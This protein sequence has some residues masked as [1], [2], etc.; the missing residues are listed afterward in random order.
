MSKRDASKKSRG[1]SRGS[2]VPPKGMPPSTRKRRA[3]QAMQAVDLAKRAVEL[4]VRG[5]SVREVA[6]EL[7][8]GVTTAHDAI[9]RGL[10]IT[11]EATKVPAEQ[12][13]AQETERLEYALAKVVDVLDTA[14]DEATRLKAAGEVRQLSQ[15]LSALHGLDA[16][17]R[18]EVTGKDGGPVVVSV[19]DFIASLAK[20]EGE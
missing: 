12:L 18:A 19:A 8:V 11:I 16:P 1:K 6:T 13:R 17:K 5:K 7:G 2:R 15:R 4:R 3:V 9:R 14:G 20:T 10:E